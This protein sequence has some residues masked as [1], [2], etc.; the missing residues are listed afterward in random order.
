MPSAQII[1]RRTAPAAKR[2]KKSKRFEKKSRS[3]EKGEQ[4]I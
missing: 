3:V 2:K 1:D 4:E